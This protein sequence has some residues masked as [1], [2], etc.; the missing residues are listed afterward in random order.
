MNKTEYPDEWT[1]ELQSK[2]GFFV[3]SSSETYSWRGLYKFMKEKLPQ[4]PDEGKSKN[5]EGE[6]KMEQFQVKTVPTHGRA[7]WALKYFTDLLL[8]QSEGLGLQTPAHS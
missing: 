2:V 6:I 5:K 1:P 4:T 8:P 3:L 7:L